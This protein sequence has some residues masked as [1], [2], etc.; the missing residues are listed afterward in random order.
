[1]Y[2]LSQSKKDFFVAKFVVGIQAIKY[3]KFIEVH[4]L[5]TRIER[6]LKYIKFGD[7]T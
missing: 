5:L 1:M 4:I 2:L 6:P 7:F 3:I